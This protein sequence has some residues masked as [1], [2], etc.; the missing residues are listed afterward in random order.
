MSKV[1][2][3][4]RKRVRAVSDIVY[5]Y[6]FRREELISRYYVQAPRG[7]RKSFMMWTDTNCPK[8]IA[9]YVKCKYIG[10]EYNLIR[11]KSGRYLSAKEIAIPEG[12]S[13]VFSDEE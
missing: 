5:D 3:V 11:K 9:Q 4:Y 7:D 12:Y 8:D 2:E 6:I 1:P 10:Q 13:A